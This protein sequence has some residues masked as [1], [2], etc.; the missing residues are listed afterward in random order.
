MGMGGWMPMPAMMPYA[1]PPQPQMGMQPIMPLAAPSHNANIHDFIQIE[2]LDDAEPMEPARPP[3]AADVDCA[4]DDEDAAPVALHAAKYNH[5]HK[6][7]ARVKAKKP[8]RVHVRPPK[9]KAAA[10]AEAEAKAAEKAAEEAELKAKQDAV[11]A[12]HE[13][14]E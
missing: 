13:T 11:A 9:V 7:G 1:Y 6:N 14:A 8:A 12:A 10:A 5:K 2:E 4:D 3:R